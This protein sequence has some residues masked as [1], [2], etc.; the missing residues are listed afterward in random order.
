MK[1]RTK[2]AAVGL[3]TAGLVALTGCTSEAD[4]VSHNL[5]LDADN[6]KIHRQIVFYNGITDKYIAEIEGLCSLGNDDSARQRTVT[7]KIGEDRYVKELFGLGDNTMVYSMQTEPTSSDPYHYKI[8]LK[9]EEV[10]P[11]IE[12]NTS[13][14]K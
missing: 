12:L 7:C 10:I 2:I 9:P 5:S 11:H 3:L 13:G 1:T 14:G 4:T 6:F 8:V